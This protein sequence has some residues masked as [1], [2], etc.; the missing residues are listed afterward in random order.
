MVAEVVSVGLGVLVVAVIDAIL[1]VV[2]EDNVGC[3]TLSID[4]IVL[5]PLLLLLTLLM[6]LLL[7][8][9]VG[10]VADVSNGFN[11]LYVHI[12]GYIV[13]VGGGMG[14]IFSEYRGGLVK[15]IFYVF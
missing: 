8:L 13:L 5:S 10:V 9:F 7:L 12:K 2:T 3:R 6:L 11:V 1:G 15:C 14:S 4:R